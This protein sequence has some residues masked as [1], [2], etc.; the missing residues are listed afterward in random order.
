LSEGLGNAFL[1]AMAC[2]LPVIATPVGGIIDFIEDGKTGLLTQVNDVE[3]L[4]TKIGQVLIDIELKRKLIEN[5]KKLVVETYGWDG[6]AQ[7]MGQIY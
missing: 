2:D 4:C 6:I 5:G 7:K 3:N 1:E